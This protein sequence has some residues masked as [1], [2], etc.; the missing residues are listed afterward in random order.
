VTTLRT[1]D[2]ATVIEAWNMKTAKTL[3]TREFETDPITDRFAI[4]Y[5]LIR[6]PDGKRL[7]ANPLT[8]WRLSVDSIAA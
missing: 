5:P 4:R 2:K 3:W 1:R 8:P 6:T 7:I